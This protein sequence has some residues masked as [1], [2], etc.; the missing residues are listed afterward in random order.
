[1]QNLKT[2]AKKSV[3]WLVA[4]ALLVT[5][6]VV[7]W[8]PAPNAEAPQTDAAGNSGVVSGDGVLVDNTQ[9]DAG[10]LPEEHPDETVSIN[11]GTSNNVVNGSQLP[12][13]QK[14]TWEAINSFPVKYADMPIAERRQ[15]CVDFFNFS[16]TALWTPKEDLTFYLS[17]GSSSTYT[18]KEGTIYGGIPYMT[19]SSGSV[20]RL[21]DFIDES[22]GVVDAHKYMVGEPDANGAYSNA[23]MKYFA[24][25]C[26]YTSFWGWARV[27]NDANYGTTYSA[28]PMEGFKLLGTYPGCSLDTL[29]SWESQGKTCT[30]SAPCNNCS[31]CNS[32]ID[33]TPEVLATLSGQTLPASKDENTNLRSVAEAD[34][35]TV[36]KNYALMEKG[37]GIVYITTAGH[38]AMCTSDAYVVDTDGNVIT[39]LSM[40]NLENVTI[41]G[42]NS[43]VL[44]TEQATD[45]LGGTSDQGDWYLYE[46]GVNSKKTFEYL[47]NY[48]YVCFSFAEFEE[49]SIL[50]ETEVSFSYTGNTITKS[51][52]FSSMV[53]ANYAIA[54]TYV[55]VTDDTGREVYRHMVRAGGPNVR[56]MKVTETATSK[57]GVN[58]LGTLTSGTYNIEIQVQLGTGERPTV[59]TGTLKV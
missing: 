10:Q 42:K 25:Q 59:Y 23:A 38:F 3:L 14:L 52:L 50:E 55:I 33:N 24:G 51:Q 27:I 29:A 54:D 13:K 15:L 34:R 32:V 17:G 45:W 53:T 6:T 26:S 2:I 46:D 49:G 47:F 22:T 1:M 43:Y 16:K 19:V 12:I 39:D 37:D 57:L 20:Y 35:Q 8:N 44:V 58:T 7:L 5:V 18:L 21:M 28:V 30:S 41:D 56:E 11:Q 36:Y 48:Y 4:A 31:S 40:E 9:G